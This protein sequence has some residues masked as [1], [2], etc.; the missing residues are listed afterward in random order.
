MCVPVSLAQTAAHP[1][2][3][4]TDIAREKLKNDC[5]ILVWTSTPNLL[6]L[7]MRTLT[8]FPMQRVRAGAIVAEVHVELTAPRRIIVRSTGLE[9]VRPVCLTYDS[10]ND[11]L[12]RARRCQLLMSFH[13]DGLRNF[14]LNA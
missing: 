3:Y 1:Q 10:G 8:G 12:R 14:L 6:K 2:E 5:S 11:A 7:G 9:P 13:L 4:V